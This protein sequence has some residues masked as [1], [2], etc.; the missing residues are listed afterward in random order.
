MVLASPFKFLKLTDFHQTWYE[1]YAT[2]LH[3]NAIYSN[4]L[5][6]VKMKWQPSCDVTNTRATYICISKQLQLL[7]RYYFETMY[8]T[9]STVN[10]FP[11]MQFSDWNATIHYAQCIISRLLKIQ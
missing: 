10:F 8:N 4:F 5:Q 7:F 6:S 1:Q 9:I 3:T 11:S 2:K